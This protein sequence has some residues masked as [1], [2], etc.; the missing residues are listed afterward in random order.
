MIEKHGDI[1]TTDKYWDC[2]CEKNFIRPKEFVNCATC[3]SCKDEQPDSRVNEL[4]ALG[5]SLPDES[6]NDIPAFNV[7][8]LGI[9][10]LRQNL[11]PK[12]DW[13]E[14]QW[15]E[16]SDDFSMNV[17]V[18]DDKNYRATAYPFVDGNVDLNNPIEVI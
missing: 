3:G 9:D 11:E 10:W 4:I 14:D 6:W 1:S 12:E 17:Y 13:P 5:F 2:E 16:L 7:K 8:K 15:A 18:D